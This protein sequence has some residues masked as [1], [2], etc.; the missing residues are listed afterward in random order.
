M[1]WASNLSRQAAKQLRSLPRDRLGQVARA[2][3]EIGEDPTLGDV[4]PVKSGRLKGALR[5]RV[6]PYRIVY[7]IDPD[8]REVNVAAILTRGE[9]TYH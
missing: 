1:N 3:D 9:T 6:G 2:I 5:K 7:S 8:A 4:R